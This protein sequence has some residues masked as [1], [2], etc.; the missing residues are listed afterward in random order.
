MSACRHIPA[1]R[2][3]GCRSQNDRPLTLFRHQSFL[4][5]FMYSIVTERNHE[6]RSVT[7]EP[8]GADLC[9]AAHRLRLRPGGS[10]CGH[11]AV[12]QTRSCYALASVLAGYVAP[13]LAAAFAGLEYQFR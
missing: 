10:H 2:F 1:I 4:L 13:A 3:A 11:A 9:V 8:K 6:P 7:I 12:G 5:E